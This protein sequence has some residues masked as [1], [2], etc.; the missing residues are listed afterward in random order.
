MQTWK[1]PLN[2]QL[3]HPVPYIGGE[4]ICA[5]WWSRTMP[6]GACVIRR[7]GKRGAVW[8]VKFVDASGRQVKERLG[9]EADGWTKRKA[10]RELRHRLAD[11]ER[12]GWRKPRAL[13]FR[14]LCRDVVR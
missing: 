13:T 1:E 8:S 14:E 7:D 4:T 6:S 12:N 2:K 9:P 11:V 3:L 10:E 5:S